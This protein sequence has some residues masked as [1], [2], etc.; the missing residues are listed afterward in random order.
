MGK[1]SYKSYRLGTF[2]LLDVRKRAGKRAPGKNKIDK[3][4]V[5]VLPNGKRMQL[6][7]FLAIT[8]G[9]KLLKPQKGTAYRFS[10]RRSLKAFKKRFST[11]Y[12]RRGKKI[13][14]YLAKGMPKSLPDA[15][16]QRRVIVLG[17]ERLTYVVR[18]VGGRTVRRRTM[19]VKVHRIHGDDLLAQKWARGFAGFAGQRFVRGRRT[20]NIYILPRG[21]IITKLQGKGLTWAQASKAYASLRS[22][23]LFR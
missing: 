4:D 1:I 10:S 8:G 18:S 6:G 12:Q 3:A 13:A 16:K 7:K 23:Y 11:A 14:R 17:N 19:T 2:K 22:R 20:R 9:M 5:L 15:I 21:R